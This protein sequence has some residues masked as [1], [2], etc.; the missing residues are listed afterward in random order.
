ML[1]P[2]PWVPEKSKFGT[3]VSGKEG[4]TVA[5]C[6]LYSAV[7]SEGAVVINSKDAY[8]NA[9]LVSRAKDLLGSVKQLLELVELLKVME[10]NP[11]STEV[12][13]PAITDARALVDL[14]EGVVLE[15]E[16]A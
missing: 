1:T 11:L 15:K 10:R 5:W 7:G 12:T 3:K 2:G 14:I 9:F 6:G 13:H 4:A 8:H 16:H